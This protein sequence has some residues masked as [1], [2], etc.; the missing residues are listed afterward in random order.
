MY[1]DEIMGLSE[2]MAYTYFIILIYKAFIRKRPTSPIYKY[3]VHIE[4]FRFLPLPITERSRCPKLALLNIRRSIPLY[5]SSSSGGRPW[6]EGP[7]PSPLREGVIS[8]KRTTVLDG[9]GGSIEQNISSPNDWEPSEKLAPAPFLRLNICVLK[10][11]CLHICR[12]LVRGSRCWCCC[13]NRRFLFVALA[14]HGAVTHELL[15]PSVRPSVRFSLSH[16]ILCWEIW[17]R[18]G[19]WR[20]QSS[21]GT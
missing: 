17:I 4:S 6:P 18:S 21:I 16:P 14:R 13:W 9:N 19:V 3:T 20:G 2:G 1:S 11:C 10:L 15:S 12:S 5:K 8:P 7:F